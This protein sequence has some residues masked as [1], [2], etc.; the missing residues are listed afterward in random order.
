MGSVEKP[1]PPTRCEMCRAGITQP[2]TGRWRKYCTQACRAKAY[3][4][5][6][7]INWPRRFETL[8]ARLAISD[9]GESRN[10]DPS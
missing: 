4:A 8:R 5:R 2:G 6:V 9:N 1:E 3:R 7:A 10:A